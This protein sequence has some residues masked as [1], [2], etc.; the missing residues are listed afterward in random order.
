LA[1]RSLSL[2]LL[3]ALLLGAAPRLARADAEAAEK[4]VWA[5]QDDPSKI[6]AA[7]KEVDAAIAQD[8]KAVKPRVLKARLMLLEARAKKTAERPA[9]F[10]AV[11]DFLAET[12][13]LDPWDP[14]PLE[15]R[16]DVLQA[17]G[18]PDH[19][20]LTETLRGVAIRKPL[21]VAA[22]RAYLR[23]AGDVPM[24]REGDPLPR[25]SWRDSKGEPVTSESLWAK[26][27]VVIELYRSAVWCPFCQRQLFA[28]H[29][30]ADAFEAAGLLV[31]AASPDTSETI[32]KIEKDGLKGKK[33]YRI[34]LLSDP[35][36]DTADALGFLNPDTVREGVRPEAYGLPF[37]TTIIVDARGI[38]R[39]VKTHR[40]FRERVKPEEMIAVA[41]RIKVETTPTK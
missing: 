19:T 28:L 20:L 2:P 37:P 17:M 25:V 8:P 21:D 1:S 15:F 40:D 16:L 18:N 27:P 32:A 11:L 4:A 39:F 23:Q 41:R 34:R 6:A 22:R 3:A 10:K 38:V 9:A 33:P 14:L 13:A 35:K 26:G 12:E 7:T 31:V 29:D 30:A 24:V 36:G 5:A